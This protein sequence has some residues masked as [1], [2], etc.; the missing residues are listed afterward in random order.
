MA[1]RGQPVDTAA[2]GPQ[3]L[4]RTNDARID[5]GDDQEVLESQEMPTGSGK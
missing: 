5:W 1:D 3:V 2:G 4:D